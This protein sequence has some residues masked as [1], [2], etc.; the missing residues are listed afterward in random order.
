MTV[1]QVPFEQVF[2]GEVN[3]APEAIVGF[4]LDELISK[5][6]LHPIDGEDGLDRFEAIPM[7]FFREDIKPIH[8]ALWRHEGN[9]PNTFA[10]HMPV[11]ADNGL[12]LTLIMGA[13]DIPEDW[14]LWKESFKID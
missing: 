9:P 14:L 12:M 10:I 3:Y 1:R 13:L 11:G 4:P 5:L 2:T 6:R 8:F 7:E